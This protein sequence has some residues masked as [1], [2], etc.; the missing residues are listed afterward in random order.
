[1]MNYKFKP[2]D[3][4]TVRNDLSLHE[5]Y[6]MLSGE[7]PYDAIVTTASMKEL[8]GKQVI[9]E[10]YDCC[11]SAMCYRVKESARCWTDEMF[12]EAMKP[13]TCKSLL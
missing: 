7:T 1:M 13:F 10:G 12:K 5:P 6:K 2:G 4:V 3:K 9:I 8:R 11:G